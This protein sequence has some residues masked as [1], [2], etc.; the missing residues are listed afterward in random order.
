MGRLLLLGWLQ[1]QT[2]TPSRV[3]IRQAQPILCLAGWHGIDCAHQ[4]AAVEPELPAELPAW[5]AEHV[6]TP[7]AADFPANATRKRP[8]IY[9]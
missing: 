6:H 5:V 3:T 4:S 9:V 8:L 2:D 7:A 1:A